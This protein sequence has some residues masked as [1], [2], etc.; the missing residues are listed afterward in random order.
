MKMQHNFEVVSVDEKGTP[1]SVKDLE[2]YVYKVNWRWWW[3][4]SEDNLSSYN[5]GSYRNEVFKTKV[6]TNSNGK[7]NFNFEIKYPEW[8]RYLVR[9]VDPKGGHATGKAM[10]IDWPGWAG[11]ANKNDPSAAT[12]L[13]FSSDKS[14]YNVGETATVTFPSSEGGRALV[15][16]ENGKL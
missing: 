11:R 4:T 3:D 5:R 9:V 2:V 12:M 14:T 1:K 15:T 6:T 13:L 10:Y 7:A 8:G 16:V